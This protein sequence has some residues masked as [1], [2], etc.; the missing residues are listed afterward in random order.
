MQLN[1]VTKMCGCERGVSGWMTV[2]M[3]ERLG[4]VFWVGGWQCAC[5]SGWVGLLGGL[6]GKWLLV[7]ERV[8]VS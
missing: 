8:D 3:L 1:T 5:F 6:L 4:G 7:A 2:C